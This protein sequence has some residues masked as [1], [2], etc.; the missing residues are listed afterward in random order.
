MA[1]I[2]N[3]NCCIY[4]FSLLQHNHCNGNPQYIVLDISLG[5]NFGMIFAVLLL[6]LLVQPNVEGKHFL[7]ETKDENSLERESPESVKPSG[8]VFL[9]LYTRVVN[10]QM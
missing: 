2:I 6:L 3:L 8:Q 9:L 7:V 1:V 10:S 4:S 5:L